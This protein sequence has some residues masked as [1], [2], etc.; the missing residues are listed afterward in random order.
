VEPSEA[1]GATVAGADH[2]PVVARSTVV[3]DGRDALDHDEGV[4][5]LLGSHS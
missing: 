5:N 4:N 1:Q 2:A 3:R